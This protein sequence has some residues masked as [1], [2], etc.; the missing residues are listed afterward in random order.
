MDV[1]VEGIKGDL[2]TAF[3]RGFT[4]SQEKGDNIKF[5][6]TNTKGSSYG[7]SMSFSPY[8][9]SYILHTKFLTLEQYCY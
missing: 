2:L 5:A 1:R 6:T 8:F 9:R 4:E 3:L 7:I